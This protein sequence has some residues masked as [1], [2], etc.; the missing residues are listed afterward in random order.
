MQ[1]GVTKS[2]L[3]DNTPPVNAFM[4]N[5]K[6]KSEPGDIIQFET[7][8]MPQPIEINGLE[9]ARTWILKPGGKMDTIMDVHY[10]FHVGGWLYTG[11]AQCGGK[12]EAA[13]RENA[14]FADAAFCTL[15]KR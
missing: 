8:H 6:F 13:A 3:V 7:V 11:F 14:G 2:R 1:F 9:G 12:T 5:T 4:I 10:R 15:K